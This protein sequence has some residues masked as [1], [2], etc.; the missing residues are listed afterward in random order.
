MIGRDGVAGLVCLAGSLVLLWASR[1]IPA[2]PL[3]PIGPG[4]YPRLVLWA[5]AAMSAL[6]VVSD[7]VSRRRA[8]AAPASYRLVVLAFAVF[9]GYAFLLPVLGFR[10]ATFLF[11]AVLQ[12]GLEWPARGRGWARVG[13][14]AFLS[15]LVTYLVFESYLYVLL[16][17]G[18]LTGF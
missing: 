3:V 5:T 18:R 6:L 2:P 11:V 8:A 17:R 13:A 16:P 4:F 1:E 10:V 14:V 12:V 9:T 15:T 7:L